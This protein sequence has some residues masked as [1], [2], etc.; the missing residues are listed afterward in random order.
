MDFEKDALQYILQQ[1]KDKASIKQLVYRNL[2]QVFSTMKNEGKRLIGELAEK[3]KEI[4]DSILVE[5]Q[6]TGDFEFSIK[7][8][9][10]TLVIHM[11]SNVITFKDDFPVMQSPYITS[12]PGRKYFGQITIYNF[13]SDSIK[14]NRL[15]DPG[16]LVARLL[17]NKENHFFVEGTGQL[18]FLFQ[19][20]ENNLITDDWLRLILEKSMAEAMD[21][22]LIG[23]N[24]PDIKSIT[25]KQKQHENLFTVRG[26]KIGFQMS[27]DADIKG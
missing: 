5:F 16:Y 12:E 13:L 8:G 6:E 19:D 21:K 22:D 15:G 26:M 9:G 25:L 24:Y 14:Y 10:D 3:L 27:T 11:Q 2:Q 18:N 7:F 20:L 4:D 17:L 23:P 1:L